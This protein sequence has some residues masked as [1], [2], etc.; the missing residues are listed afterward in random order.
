M[1]DQYRGANYDPAAAHN[2]QG[3]T[4]VAA[5]PVSEPAAAALTANIASDHQASDPLAQTKQCVV[6]LGI[7]D[8]STNKLSTCGSGSIVRSDGYIVTAAH[9]VMPAVILY[10]TSHS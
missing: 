6:Q 5:P 1:T 8:L 7:V 3:G 9:V 4:A 2:Q 10:S